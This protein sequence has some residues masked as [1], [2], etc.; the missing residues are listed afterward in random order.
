MAECHDGFMVTPEVLM[1]AA[2][3]CPATAGQAFV[4]IQDKKN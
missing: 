1:A 4:V 3:A 2:A